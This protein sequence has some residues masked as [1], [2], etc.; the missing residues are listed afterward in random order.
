M[1]K[2]R[3]LLCIIVLYIYLYNPP[4][5][6]VGFGLIKILLLIAIFYFF[7]HKSCLRPYKP[8]L[9]YM[10]AITAFMVI[11]TLLI[12]T[13]NSGNALNTPYGLVLWYLES[14]YLPVYVVESYA[15]E[16]NRSGFFNILL[17]LGFG[18]SIISTIL[19]I[20]PDLNNLVLG[21]VI[22]IPY[23]NN[24]GY[25]SRCFGIAEGLTNSY[26]IIQGVFASLC[27]LF[28]SKGKWHYALFFVFLT[29]ATMVN[30]RTGMIAV[31]ITI[32]WKFFFSSAKTKI[33][34]LFLGA[35]L[36]IVV[37]YLL[38]AYA[39]DYLETIESITSFFTSSYDYIIKGETGDDYY[40]ALERF[41][42][43]PST[44]SGW[45][46]GEGRTLF[47]ARTG[48]SDIGFVN[49][50]FIGGIVFLISLIVVQFYI[51]RNLKKNG[52]HSFLVWL[53]FCT[54][55]IINFKGVT[56][57]TTESFSRFVMLYFFVLIY[58]KTHH[59]NQ[60]VLLK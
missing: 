39:E 44:I 41:I 30:A 60:I 34:F 11:Y 37:I 33:V 38:N 18:A 3:Y 19:L 31:I 15:K 45:L 28:L 57:C 32:I 9:E 13:I 24:F 29:L 53:L 4:F 46:F 8:Y 52:G 40:D 26:G 51:Y 17:L 49:Q 58:N 14:V 43:Y 59:D 22:T 36:S 42:H 27:L 16:F 12:V 50:I 54:A 55:F 23:E 6:M 10:G 20:R 2:V 48:S 1:K 21:S 35:V 47:G 7:R 56:F 5:V 25:W